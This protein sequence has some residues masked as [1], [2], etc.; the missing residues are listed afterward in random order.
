MKVIRKSMFQ[1]TA[2]VLLLL[3]IA[4][5]ASWTVN[6][7]GLFIFIHN[8][9]WFVGDDLLTDIFAA[10]FAFAALAFPW[11]GVML[12]LREFTKG[13]ATIKDEFRVLNREPLPP[14]LQTT[15][16]QRRIGMGIFAIVFGIAMIFVNLL[17]MDV[18]QGELTGQWLLVPSLLVVGVFL[19][20]NGLTTKDK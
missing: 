16:R 15:R 19:L 12:V 18:S 11:I 17:I 10:F 3:I 2:L 5:V 14:E 9:L 8:M 6:R 7:S 13:M 4:V 20:T 1:F